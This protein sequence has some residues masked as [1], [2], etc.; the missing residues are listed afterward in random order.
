MQTNNHQPTTGEIKKNL[1]FA[2]WLSDNSAGQPVMPNSK[3]PKLMT[4]SELAA[5]CKSMERAKN[6]EEV[7]AHLESLRDH[8]AA[9]VMQHF[10]RATYPRQDHPEYPNNAAIAHV[11]KTWPAVNAGVNVTDLPP[12]RIPKNKPSHHPDQLRK[13]ERV[14]F[15]TNFDNWRRR[16]EAAQRYLASYRQNDATPPFPM[17]EDPDDDQQ[18]IERAGW[19]DFWDHRDDP[20]GIPPPDTSK[21][22]IPGRWL[23]ESEPQRILA[24]KHY[25]KAVKSISGKRAANPPD[26]IP[27][28]AQRIIEEEQSGDPVKTYERRRKL[29]V[30]HE[31]GKSQISRLAWVN[32]QRE[33]WLTDAV[34]AA[35]RAFTLIRHLSNVHPL[36]TARKMLKDAPSLAPALQVLAEN[37]KA[38]AEHGVSPQ[39]GDTDAL[40][41]ERLD[42]ALRPLRRLVGNPP[43]HADCI[44]SEYWAR[45]AE[46]V[47]SIAAAATRYELPD[48]EA[49]FDAEALQAMSRLT[50]EELQQTALL[51]VTSPSGPHDHTLMLVPDEWVVSVMTSVLNPEHDDFQVTHLSECFQERTMTQ[52]LAEMNQELTEIRECL[53]QLPELLAEPPEDSEEF[54][55]WAN[56]TGDLV[57]HDLANEEWSDCAAPEPLPQLFRSMTALTYSDGLRERMTAKMRRNIIVAA[58]NA[59]AEA[60]KRRWNRTQ[61]ELRVILPIINP[62]LEGKPS[63]AGMN[64]YA[65]HFT[66]YQTVA[67]L[68]SAIEPLAQEEAR[69]NPTVRPL[70]PEQPAL[71]A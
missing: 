1:A 29:L 24:D 69:A 68:L 55:A 18:L 65:T 23:P 37:R 9:Y 31:D 48:F 7:R 17:V 4:P 3:H 67:S 6:G 2:R 34:E 16:I 21:P 43:E 5:A 71:I 13:Q 50:L 28:H 47:D 39:S 36:A 44:V 42:Q 54:A 33:P 58:R 8:A 10:P 49:K 66:L 63:Q 46:A 38:R 45:V 51:Q 20:A 14:N 41:L 30:K 52:A 25:E 60:A 56:I 40:D 59:W 27:A 15:E 22:A 32:G 26:L 35:N 11:A 61:D 62:A 19:Q 57:R 70:I 53:E 12:L 64:R